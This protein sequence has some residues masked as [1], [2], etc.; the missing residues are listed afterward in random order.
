MSF[1]LM[2]VMTSYCKDICYKG[3]YSVFNSSFYKARNGE[4][5]SICLVLFLIFSV[6][7]CFAQEE[8]KAIL[9]EANNAYKIGQLEKVRECLPDRKIRDMSSK[10][11]ISA[12]RLLT[13]YY[14][15][16]DDEDSA[17]KY[18]DKMLSVEGYYTPST[19]DPVIFNLL[20]EEVA[21]TKDDLYSFTEINHEEGFSFLPLI[22]IDRKMIDDIGANTLEDVLMA[23]APGF[24][25][26][27]SPFEKSM[28][29]RGIYGMNQQKVLVASNGNVL[30][31]FTTGACDL[32]LLYLTKD[33][34]AI[35]IF[36][37]GSPKVFSNYSYSCVINLIRGVDI[38]RKGSTAV[39]VGAGNYRTGPLSI[40]FEKKLYDIEISVHTNVYMANGEK[41][42]VSKE[43][44]VGTNT[45]KGGDIYLGRIQKTKDSDIGLNIRMGHVTILFNYTGQM[46]RSPY[47]SLNSNN[48]DYGGVYD[49]SKY[50]AYEGSYEPGYTNTTLLAGMSYRT[51]LG[52]KS[53]LSADMLYK[54]KM[55]YFFAPLTSENASTTSDKNKEGTWKFLF[56]DDYSLAFRFSFT[57]S[58]GNK[59]FG[60]KFNVGVNVERE[61]VSGQS[62]TS[63]YYYR[64]TSAKSGLM[65]ESGEYSGCLYGDIRHNFSKNWIVDAGL[66]CTQKLDIHKN[67][68]RYL[69]PNLSLIYVPDSKNWDMRFCYFLNVTDAPYICRFFD[70]LVLP[71]LG[72]NE[73]LKPEK[74]NTFQL[75]FNHRPN[76]KLSWSATFFY[77]LCKDLIYYDP[78]MSTN[79]MSPFSNVNEFQDYGIEGITSLNLNRI[80]GQFNISWIMASKSDGYPARGH[81]IYNIPTFTAKLS[82]AGDVMKHKKYGDL[83]LHTSLCFTSSQLSP[84]EKQNLIYI[85][86]VLQDDPNH[87]VPA[88]CIVNLGADYHWRFLSF[89][90]QCTNLFNTKYVQGGAT[91]VPYVQEGRWIFGKV[92]ATF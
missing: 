64:V 2:F 19:E 20:I 27:S 3:F 56:W 28:S 66:K 86:N 63:G 49:Y 16:V 35:E 42:S 55:H 52:Y 71:E 69:M 18:A 81:R 83:S 38:D 31:S 41:I 87:E 46:Q 48:G 92:G 30:N 84:M 37:G 80:R 13:L 53:S 58:Y 90:L 44:A 59:G 60:G 8:D 47:I 77:N 73:D 68:D 40:L 50:K 5:L 23:Y 85:G 61:E 88:R 89:G 45:P 1:F 67:K 15:G 26:V 70:K 34:K 7:L 12:Y 14:L 76:A 75:N 17:K 79:I 72:G 22:H 29:F 82:V 43:E 74:I 62:L 39:E 4:K 36:Y 25:V 10:D 51:T 65:T 91:F 9:E 32:S 6:N 11:K 54:S 33:I 78:Y 21:K 57:H 24:N